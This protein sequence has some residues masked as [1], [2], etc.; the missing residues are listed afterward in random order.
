MDSWSDKQIA[1]MRVGGNHK[2][3]DFLQKYGVEKATPIDKKYNSA[4]AAFY[5]KMIAAEVEGTEVPVPPESFGNEGGGSDE[6][7]VQKEL[8][9]REDARERLRQ[10][11]GHS[12]GLSSSG[13]IMQG[14]GS[15]SSY[16]P[17]PKDSNSSFIPGG[18]PVDVDKLADASRTAFTFLSASLSTLGDSVLKVCLFQSLI[19]VSLMMYCLQTATSLIDETA[20]PSNPSPSFNNNE[21]EKLRSNNNNNDEW[22]NTW[23]S[24]STTAASLWK[25]ASDA[26]ADIVNNLQQPGEQSTP[27]FNDSNANDAGRA[28]ASNNGGISGSSRDQTL[29]QKPSNGS[30]KKATGSSDDFFATFGV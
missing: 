29:D 25:S 2:C 26:T 20:N 1:F 21:S 9:A 10:K 13:G 6:D 4:A 19:S 27:S 16:Q 5:R 17:G 22:A 3:N 11:F 23:A 15:D 30:A 8:K 24:F 28:A 12:A 14:I 18:L 7:Y